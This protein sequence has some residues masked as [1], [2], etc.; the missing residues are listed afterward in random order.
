MAQRPSDA[1]MAVWTA[2]LETHA[3]LVAKL[4]RELRDA[5]GLSLE[6]YDALHVLYAA[7][8]SLRMSELAERS[9]LSRYNCTRLVDRLAKAG[10][11]RRNRSPD[12]QR[13]VVA[14]LTTAGRA[15]VR[16]AGVTHLA[17]IRRHVD[18]VLDEQS[19][20]AAAA[21]LRTLG[22]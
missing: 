19:A 1:A 10:L 4:D 2:L 11:V 6:W 5:H 9:M 7:G 18:G 17:G 13:G 21:A 16:R 15:L 3:V 20:L 8:G 12:D 22:R 14:E